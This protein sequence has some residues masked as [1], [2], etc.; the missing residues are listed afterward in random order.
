MKKFK[1]LYEEINAESPIISIE[2]HHSNLN[3]KKTVNEINKNL[4]VMLTKSFSNLDDG[5]NSIKKILSMYSIQLPKIEYDNEL[6]GNV[7]IP[8]SQFKSSGESH[9]NVTAP[10]REKDERH[11][12]NMK[13]QIQNGIYKISAKISKL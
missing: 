5:L 3:D 4:D 1:T 12:F 13:Y 8:V 2:K 9:F 11:N 7:N 6:K 10:F